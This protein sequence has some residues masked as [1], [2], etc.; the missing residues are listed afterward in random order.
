[1]YEKDDGT[2]NKKPPVHVESVKYEKI[3]SSFDR[4]TKVLTTNDETMDQLIRRMA[5]LLRRR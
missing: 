4:I 2:E 1:M 3:M 5:K